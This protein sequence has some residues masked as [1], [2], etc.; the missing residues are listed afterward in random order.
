MKNLLILRHAKSSWN[1]PTLAD[2]DRPLN[3]RG[4]RDAPRMGEHLRGLGLV[5]DHVISSTAVRAQRTAKL[6]GEAAGYEGEYELTRLFYHAGVEEYIEGLM[7]VPE[8]NNTV[9]IVG[10]NPGMEELLEHL[11]GD[12]EVMTTAHIARVELPIGGHVYRGAAFEDFQ[13][14]Y[15]YGDYCTGYVWGLIRDENGAWLD[16]LMFTTA[17]NIT[18]FGTDE[19]GEIY[20]VARS[21]VVYELVRQ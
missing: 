19:A 1:S 10:H 8:V 12:D 18:S 2:H 7:T 20:L 6:V 13:G 15:L 11:T 14:V 5:P 9:M 4:K 3:S 16:G 17:V 21:G